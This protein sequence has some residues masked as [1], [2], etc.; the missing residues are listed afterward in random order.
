MSINSSLLWHVEL[1]WVLK[2]RLHV[3]SSAEAACGL[4]CMCHCAAALSNSNA[5][6]CCEALMHHMI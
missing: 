2:A 6:A 4:A 5:I 1:P 3:T